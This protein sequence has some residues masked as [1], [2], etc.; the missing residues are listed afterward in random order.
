[1]APWRTWG[2]GAAGRRHA[3]S[4]ARFIISRKTKPEVY[5]PN[6]APGPGSARWSQTPSLTF[7][8]A[9]R[10][11]GSFFKPRASFAAQPAPRSDPP[12]GAGRIGPGERERAPASPVGTPST[13]GMSPAPLCPPQGVLPGR[14]PRST[15]GEDDELRARGGDGDRALGALQDQHRRPG[16]AAGWSRDQHIERGGWALGEQGEGQHRGT[17][18]TEPP[19]CAPGDGAAGRD[20]GLAML[21]LW[22]WSYGL[23]AGEG[24]RDATWML[25]HTTVGQN[26][27]AVP[28]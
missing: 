24:C 18:G 2:S 28:R 15:H 22:G 6:K 14:C 11:N 1:M 4:S 17:A 27:P 21:G 3:G 13:P 16:A 19:P 10:G 7:L 5:F 25:M 26:P 20:G 9:A 8:P 12:P 23:G